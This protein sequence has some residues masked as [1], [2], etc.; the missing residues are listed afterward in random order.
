[1]QLH[2]IKPK[3]PTKKKKQIG[4][5]GAHGFHGGRGNEGQRSRAGKR[6]QPVIRELIKKYPKLRGYQFKSKLRT[7]KPEMVILDLA[8]LEKKFEAGGKITPKILLEKKIISRIKGRIPPVKILG[9]GEL[10]KKLDIADCLIS[11]SAKEKI[12]KVGG[13]VK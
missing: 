9:E 13:T 8:V 4:R 7:H 2:Q 5:G 11:K 1:M 3:H 12:I 6:L 10:T